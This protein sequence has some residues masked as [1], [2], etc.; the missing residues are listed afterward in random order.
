[1]TSWISQLNIFVSPPHEKRFH[2][3]YAML[4][5]PHSNIRY[6]QSL[7]SLATV[8]LQCVLK[9]WRVEAE[10][11]LKEIGGESFLTFSCPEL[12]EEVWRAVSENAGCCFA[13]ELRD[14]LLA[15]LS[16]VQ[17]RFYPEDLSQL[18][19]YK[20]KTNADFTRMLLHC[21]KAASL[22]YRDDEPL[23]VLDPM[24]GKGT[25]LF[26]ALEEGYDA[27]G[28]DP[29]GKALREAEQTLG[30]S[31][32]LNRFK[33]KREE[34]S[35]TRVQKPPLRCV[36]YT[37]SATPEAWKENERRSI[38]FVEG[39]I[40]ALP[41]ALSKESCHLAV[42]D[43]PYGVQHA[44][45]AGGRV[46][47]LENLARQGARSCFAVLRHGGAAAFSFN[48]NTLSRAAT[49]DALQSAGFK[50]LDDA[51]YNGFAHWVEQA[52]NRDAVVAVKP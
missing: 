36:R 10:V 32:K 23:T 13:A 38:R 8:E 39:E 28:L 24:C 3:R 30:R 16:R 44:P 52:V 17:R 9:A 7:Q 19:K 20:G 27:V 15:P 37:L 49:L 21:A 41:D 43:L 11:E 12:R 2:V 34:L 47:S 51:P 14:G 6:R 26:C 42:A 31:L 22:F 45:S 46:S 18:L 1:M 25:T 35:L 33:H 40:R 48:T 29:D 50:P 5:K 4:L